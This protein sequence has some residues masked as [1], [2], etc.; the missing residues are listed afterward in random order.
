[1]GYKLSDQETVFNYMHDTGEWRIY[2]NVRKHITKYLPL[3][4]KPVK[5]SENGRVISL[6]G[7]LPNVTIS[8]YR[9][10]EIDAKTRELMGERLN[11]NLKR[12]DS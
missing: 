8:A 9:K 2:T 5:E 1:M 3:V 12:G 6:E 4:K 7:T 11:Q 10:R